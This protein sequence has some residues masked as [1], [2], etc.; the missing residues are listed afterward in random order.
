MSDPYKNKKKIKKKKKK[1]TRANRRQNRS[2]KLAIRINSINI[3]TQIKISSLNTI[4]K[5]VPMSKVGEL[6]VFPEDGEGDGDLVVV[7]VV[8]VVVFVG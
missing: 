3:T 1:K 2:Q 6:D 5:G 8:V 7:V 4:K